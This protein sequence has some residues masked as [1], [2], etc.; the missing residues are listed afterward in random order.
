M[1]IGFLL[2]PLITIAPYPAF[3]MEVA[4]LPPACDSPRF[5][6]RGLLNN[7]T[8]LDAKGYAGVNGPIAKTITFSSLK[9]SAL[10]FNSSFK[11]WIPT[12][13]PPIHS[14]KRSLRFTIS[15]LYFDKSI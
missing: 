4:V 11:S 15:Y 7:A 12:P 2:L 14:S 3:A 13:T 9:G 1:Y 10:R 6:V 8:V 5:P